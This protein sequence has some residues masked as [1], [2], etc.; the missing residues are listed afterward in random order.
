MA[1]LPV[2][3]ARKIWAR[4]PPLE[5]G[6]PTRRRMLSGGPKW[7]IVRGSPGRGLQIAIFWV[8]ACFVVRRAFLELSRSVSCKSGLPPAPVRDARQP[9]KWPSCPSGRLGKSGPGPPSG[10]WLPH[11][12]SNAIVWPEMAH[13]EGPQDEA[14]KSRF[15]GSLP[16]SVVR[17]AFLE[18]TRSVSCKDSLPLPSKALSDADRPESTRCRLR[19][20][21]LARQGPWSCRT[22]QKGRGGCWDPLPFS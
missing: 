4:P 10:K 13:C 19:A 6:L 5:R 9:G 12:S 1:F 17:R 2:W 21:R 14:S 8:S 11:A 18:P 20:F 3:P 15:S 16:F 7:L 22:R